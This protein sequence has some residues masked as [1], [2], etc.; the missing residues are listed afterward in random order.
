MNE[1]ALSYLLEMHTCPVTKVW[2]YP[3]IDG[4]LFY[5][6]DGESSRLVGGC[7]Y[8]TRDDKQDDKEY[9]AAVAEQLNKH[10]SRLYKYRMGW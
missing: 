8:I 10:S 2:A 3:R 4:A 5:K 6:K 1:K 7:S 9:A